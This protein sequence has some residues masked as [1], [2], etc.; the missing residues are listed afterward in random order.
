MRPGVVG[1]VLVV[2]AG[3]V[4]GGAVWVR[5]GAQLDRARQARDDALR[6]LGEGEL[7]RARSA[8]EDALVAADTVG[9]LTGRRESALDV[10]DE[11]RHGLATIDAL[12][13][14]D[15]EAA[16]R[17]L[18]PEGQVLGQP[19]A[20]AV[21][22][23]IDRARAEALVDAG[24]ALEARGAVEL[25]PRVL[26]AAAQA[27]QT[28][29]SP[30]AA[31]AEQAL[32]R[33]R[34]RAR[35][36][37]AE[38]A[39]RHARDAEAVGM[40]RALRDGLDAAL[41]PFPEAERLELRG[42]VEVAAAEVADRQVV[43][44]FEEAVAALARRVPTND[45][46]GLLPEVEALEVPTLRGGHL[47]AE[48]LK[49][50]LQAA[51]DLR[52]RVLDR[53][54]RFAGMVLAGRF[55]GALIY[56]DRTEVT[57]AAYARFVAAGGYED[58]KYWPTEAQGRVERFRDRTR[59][60]GPDGWRDGKPPPGK[61]Q[62]PVS[63]VCIYEAQAYAKFVGKRLPTLEEWRAAALGGRAP[64]AYPW[65]DAWKPGAAHV[66]EGDPPPSDTV[67]VG[68]RPEGRSPSGAE[69][70][71]GNVRELI[72][73]GDKVVAVGG[74]YEVRPPDATLQKQV[75]LFPPTLRP[76]DVGFR[77]ALELDWD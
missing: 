54:Q 10:A 23:R 66:R 49:V 34:L 11:A 28:S 29:Q 3:V 74:S 45:L 59:K 61:E 43:K 16:L 64:T 48:A 24:L 41:E 68:S 4:A 69:D 42:R 17:S 58:P 77:C 70:M 22:A 71:I 72:A 50:R 51:V 35:L 63:G 5:D 73:V 8:F 7:E 15:G 20:P 36:T 53:A 62:H 21:Q 27:A 46:G 31:D 55:G 19:P 32:A 65:G 44:R 6:L 30:R 39:V 37:E 33:A 76:A 2:G 14:G 75:E 12:L 60:P 52:A 1:A 9:G 67:P 13:S 25:A 26:E 57:N 18:G 47:D 56:V 38:E 40:L